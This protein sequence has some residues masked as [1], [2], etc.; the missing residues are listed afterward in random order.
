MPAKRYIF[1]SLSPTFLSHRRARLDAYLHHILDIPQL[2]DSFALADFLKEDLTAP[3]GV[4]GITLGDLDEHIPNHHAKEGKLTTSG[5]GL[6]SKGGNA[7]E[8]QKQKHRA[9]RE[10]NVRSIVAGSHP[11]S[12]HTGKSPIA[13]AALAKKKSRKSSSAAQTQSQRAAAVAA[14]SKAPLAVDTKPAVPDLEFVDESGDV[15]DV[16]IPLSPSQVIPGPG[17]ADDKTRLE[18]F[19]LLRVIG[20]GSYGKVMLARHKAT[21]QVYAVKAISKREL[22]KRPHEIQRIMAERNVLRANVNHPFL[23]GLRYSFQS[24]ARLY[25]CVDYVNGGELFFHLQKERRFSPDRVRFYAAEIASALAY[26]HSL[27]IIYR[28]LKPENC[29]LDSDGH[30][31]IVDFGLA[32]TVTDLPKQKTSTF[33]GTPEYLAPEVLAQK[34]YGLAVDW[35]C[36]GALVHEMLVGL[37][38]FYST[39]HAEMYRR[40]LT[41]R[42]S[43]HPDYI[44]DGATRDFLTRLLERNPAKRLGGGKAGSAE[45]MGHPYFNG[46]DWDVLYRKEYDPPYKPKVTN[47]M[48]LRHIDPAFTQD[49]ISRSLRK[50]AGEIMS[51]AG[52]QLGTTASNG[53]LSVANTASPGALVGT[54]ELENAF[55]GFSFEPGKDS[56]LRK[57]SATADVQRRQESE[58]NLW[59][60]E[61]GIVTQE[62]RRGPY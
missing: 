60:A 45:V 8:R 57:T 30:V 21:G 37:P 13:T 59:G 39:D 4:D 17:N 7:R 10:S 2:R 55:V 36:L 29:L 11:S 48:D 16:G 50:E 44:R 61:G 34:P 33:C 46:I 15:F 52:S 58:D 26:L 20:K 51:P 18:D 41:E 28:D 42:L 24:P 54:M 25:F 12:S 27:G 1:S 22:R 35:Y 5:V 40:I 32:K 14:A 53:L 9:R 31:R 49:P 47:E 23:V 6:T 62:A 56:D 38:P 43:L 3:N 19:V